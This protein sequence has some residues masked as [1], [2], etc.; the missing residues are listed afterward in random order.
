MKLVEELVN[1]LLA[2]VFS[3][4]LAFCVGGIFSVIGVCE[5][6][7]R[8]LRKIQI[9]EFILQDL[10]RVGASS[11]EVSSKSVLLLH[12]DEGY[13]KYIF[14]RTGDVGKLYR[15]RKKHG[16][17]GLNLISLDDYSISFSREASWI[18]VKLD[19]LTLCFSHIR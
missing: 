13:L 7:A 2:S 15:V 9:L 6:Y 12:T 17:P 11:C 3:L 18:R 4:V 8:E 10:R 19:D 5:M 14:R 1:F 16:R